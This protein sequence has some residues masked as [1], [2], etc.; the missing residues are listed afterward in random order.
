MM[1]KKVVRTPR[2]RRPTRFDVITAAVAQDHAH[3]STE[4]ITSQRSL[5]MHESSLLS[6]TIVQLE[7]KLKAAKGQFANVEASLVGLRL[8]VE[9]R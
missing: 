6:D 7:A 1:K 5:L 4:E 3:C 2:A 8:V 9:R